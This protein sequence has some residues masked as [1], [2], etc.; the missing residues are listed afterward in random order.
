MV[1]WG[2]VSSTSVSSIWISS[3][4]ED[5]FRLGKY[6]KKKKSFLDWP[7]IVGLS[8]PQ[9]LLPLHSFLEMAGRVVLTVQ[10][11]H[12]TFL[13][14]RKVGK[15]DVNHFVYPLQVI[16]VLANGR[17][18]NIR[19]TDISYT[20]SKCKH[21]VPNN[22]NCYSWGN[23]LLGQDSAQSFTEPL[24]ALRWGYIFAGKVSRRWCL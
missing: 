1:S 20:H 3:S 8:T 22:I 21:N 13:E 10:R 23:V 14:T 7:M 19:S 9:W 15:R 5:L 16:G 12:E 18:S 17:H 2:F 11:M 24:P 4:Y 6:K